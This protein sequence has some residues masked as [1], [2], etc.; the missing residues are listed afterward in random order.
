[1][2]LRS[3][4]RRGKARMFQVTKKLVIEVVL[5]VVFVSGCSPQLAQR[6]LVEGVFWAAG[7]GLKAQER[8]R[9]RA[10]QAAREQALRNEL[11]EKLAR[12]QRQ[13]EA[14]GAGNGGAVVAS[15]K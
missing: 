3:A 10:A 5:L 7:Q 8:Q 15:G 6:V 4:I 12:M 13:L 9:E 11:E 14:R 2:G 1:M